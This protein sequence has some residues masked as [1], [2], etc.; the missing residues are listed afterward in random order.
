MTAVLCI[1][2]GALVYLALSHGEIGFVKLKPMKLVRRVRSRYAS[3]PIIFL[4]YRLYFE[5]L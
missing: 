5:F 4:S 3:N 1:V 2:Y